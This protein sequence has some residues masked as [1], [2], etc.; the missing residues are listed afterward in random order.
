[1]KPSTEEDLRLK[2]VLLSDE[3]ERLRGSFTRLVIE[4]TR[5]VTE[6]QRFK[7]TL[8]DAEVSTLQE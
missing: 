4:N 1:M 6:L 7:E 3:L 5:L 8:D 2:I